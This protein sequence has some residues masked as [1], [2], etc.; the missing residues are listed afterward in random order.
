MIPYGRQQI[1][2]EDIDT[3]TQVLK[4]DFVTQGPIVDKFEGDIC[5]FTGAKYTIAVNSATSAL[6]I[7]CKSL[8]LT[9]GDWLWTVSNTFVASANCALYCEAKVDFVDIDP[10]TLNISIECLEK[11]LKRAQEKNELPK[12]LVPVHF[13]GEPCDLHSIKT[14]SKKYGFA[15]L[16]DASH[17][18][19]SSYKKTKTGSCNFS[20]ITVFSFHPVKIITTGEG[21]AATT[22]CP[23]L[24]EKM[25]LL[26]SHGITRNPEIMEYEP[27][28][29]WEYQQ[30][31][32]GWNYRMTDIH[33]ALGISQLERLNEYVERRHE[34][35]KIY[36]EELCDSNIGIPIKSLNSYSS[37]HL[38]IINL[39]N[40][41]KRK[42][43]F[44]HLRKRKIGVNVHYKPVHLQPYY[45]KL[46]FK[47][48]YCPNAEAY[49]DRCLSLPLF[50][51]M[52]TVQQ[53]FVIKAIREF[54]FA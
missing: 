35:A 19:G 42:L 5:K 24:Y 40:K 43:L 44:N 20:D 53:K 34:L 41:T 29:Q 11:K 49:Y 51:A 54:K 27:E 7:A 39:E 17:A 12:V 38:Y 16:E 37:Y 30:I 10:H 14:L 6:H 33:A 4:S 23:K 3:V 21:G 31:E 45:Q 1:T 28:G 46:G 26:R 50:P 18:I 15:I 48:G 8:G 22:N 32:L 36:N 13:S 25:Q 47:K 2:Q 9:R 52:T